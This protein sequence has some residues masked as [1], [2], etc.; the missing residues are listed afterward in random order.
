MKR[1]LT[2]VLAVLTAGGALAIATAPVATPAPFP[3]MSGN[4]CGHRVRNS[5]HAE[6][7]RHDHG[8]VR[9]GE[10]SLRRRRGHPHRRAEQQWQDAVD[11]AVEEFG[12]LT[13]VRIRR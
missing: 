10:R 13:R 7:Q 3:S 8:E 5:D 1:F 4:R 12:Q 2:A 9:S 6:R 11:F